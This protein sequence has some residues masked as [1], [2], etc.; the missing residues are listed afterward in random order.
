MLRSSKYLTGPV[1]PA[2]VILFGLAG[3]NNTRVTLGQAYVAPATL[4]LHGE[5]STKSNVAAELKHGERVEIVDVQRRM[6]RVRTA[7]GAEGWTDSAQ[8][9]SQEQMDALRKR[10]EQEKLLPPEGTATAYEALNVHIDPDRQSPAFAQIPESG[11]V[12]VLGHKLVP[13]NANAARTPGLLISR[14]QALSRRQKKEQKSSN[15]SFRLPPKPAP[16]KPP[17]NWLEL[18]AERIDKSSDEEESAKKPEAAKA[19]K[20]AAGGKSKSEL[21]PVVM[22]D[23][24]LVRTKNN[25]IGWVLTRN[26][27]MSI[28]DEV[29]QYAEGKNITGFFD[30]GT[31]NDEEKGVKHNW[32]WTTSSRGLPYDFDSWRVF[33]WNT[34]K[35]RYETSF[36]QRDL[37]GYFP[38]RVQPPDNGSPMRTF[39]IVTKDD[40][41]KLRVRDYTFDGHLVRLANTA[42]YNPAAEE[43]KGAAL[44]TK[45]LA[46]KVK[47]PNWF[48]RQ[49]A[50]I[51]RRFGGS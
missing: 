6:V 7:K 3:C 47:P 19:T 49:W 20:P 26:L 14:P 24:T 9:L 11:S 38:V 4:R 37:E 46:S 28:P 51:K 35:H 32:L 34:R 33:L 8:L 39:S 42:D 2:T 36:R 43:A 17:A 41:G 48:K 5:V 21:K 22:D 16:P 27:L 13:K 18:S 15:G 23:W 25:E 10:Q 30:M 29:A 40:D 45:D 12:T 1:F 31:V 44:D 50:N